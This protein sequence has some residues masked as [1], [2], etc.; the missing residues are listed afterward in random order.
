MSTGRRI[1]LVVALMSVVDLQ[2]NEARM[3]RNMS[4]DAERA[5]SHLSLELRYAVRSVFRV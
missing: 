2:W 3:T 1:F 5:L 4:R